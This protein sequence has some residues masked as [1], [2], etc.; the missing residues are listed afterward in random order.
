MH[1]KTQEA[2]SFRLEFQEPDDEQKKFFFI[3]RVEIKTQR[4]LK[5][6]YIM[7]KTIFLLLCRLETES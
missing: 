3:F 2:R 7:R 4:N 6:F 1:V 5:L